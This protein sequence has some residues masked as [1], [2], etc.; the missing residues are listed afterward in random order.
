MK[1]IIKA[2]RAMFT[3]PELKAERYTYDVPTPSAIKGVL[4]SIYW[5]PEMQYKIHAIKVLNEIRHQE[6]MMSNQTK[7]VGKMKPVDRNENATLRS[8]TILVDVAYVVDFDIELT[9]KGTHPNDVVEKHLAIFARRVQQGQQYRT[10]YLGCREF[11]CEVFDAR[12]YDIP[13]SYYEGTIRELGVMLHHIEY[14]QNGNKAVW[15]RPRMLNGVIYCQESSEGK[16][17]WVFEQ[18]VNFYDN[19]AERCNLPVMG[20]SKEKISFVMEIDSEGNPTAFYPLEVNA[21]NKVVPQMLDVPEMV[22]GRTSGVKANFA[23]DNCRYVFGLDKKAED[24]QNKVTAFSKKFE[25]VTKGVEDVEV[26][27]VKAFYNKKNYIDAMPLL[28]DYMDSTQAIMGN[29][30]LKVKGKDHFV[31]ENKKIREAWIKYYKKHIEGETITCMVTGKKDVKCDM[32]P[33]I[34]GVAGSSAFAKLVSVNA[35]SFESYGWKA[36]DNCP[37]GRT[38]VFKYATAL[39]Y[40]LSRFEHRLSL[41]QSTYVFWSDLNSPELLAF[42]KYALSGYKDED[43]DLEKIPEGEHFYILELKVNASR[44]YIK[45]FESFIWN[46]D[47][48]IDRMIRF[49]RTMKGIK[50]RTGIWDAVDSRRKES[51]TGMK[52]TQGYYLGQLMA[53]CEKAQKDA[54]TSTR[55]TKT[56]ADF[57]IGAASTTPAK[58]FPKILTQTQHHINKINYGTRGM[59]QDIMENLAEFDVPYPEYLDS[60]EQC[61]FFIGYNLK[62]KEL[63]TPRNQSKDK[64]TNETDETE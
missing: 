62:C 50:D 36:M 23:W 37:I 31:H 22:A 13:Q 53:V 54:V 52:K 57:Y 7:G 42:I 15:Y 2:K 40:M 35:P 5:K 12:G 34:K 3:R 59:I 55:S 61:A 39:N 38:T 27:A 8:M 29:I 33:V 58:V 41:N 19:N 26:Q 46:E 20:F 47:D 14:G 18:L 17:G 1:V 16:D 10:P 44:L 43:I 21:K 49:L 51:V 28:K 6:V 24:G 45:Q 56:V 9:G 64:D 11:V 25:E 32:H 30:V 60:Q 48:C 4:E 63:Y